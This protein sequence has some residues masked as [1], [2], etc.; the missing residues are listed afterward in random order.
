MLS[1]MKILSKN[2]ALN[3]IVACNNTEEIKL[4]GEVPKR[5]LARY[6]G[7]YEVADS[8]ESATSEAALSL[9]PGAENLN[10]T[11]QDLAN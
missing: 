11:L 5:K 1:L 3:L 8:N 2:P 4:T 7:V 10:I 6:L 9:T